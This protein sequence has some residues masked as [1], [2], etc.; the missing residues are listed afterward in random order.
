[1]IFDIMVHDPLYFEVGIFSG[2]PDPPY[3]SENAQM[4]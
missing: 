2:P 4:C 3:M 1:M